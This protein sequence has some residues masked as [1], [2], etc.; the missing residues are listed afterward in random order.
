MINDQLTPEEQALVE[1]LRSTPKPQI[2]ASSRA[3]IRE[4]LLDE[5][6]TVMAQPVPT[7]RPPRLLRFAYGLVAAIVVVVAAIVIAQTRGQL[8]QTGSEVT[9]TGSQIP[10]AVVPSETSALPTATPEPTETATT[11]AATEISPTPTTVVPSAT[12]TEIPSTATATPEP[13]ETATTQAPTE[14]SPTPTTVVPSAT[15]TEIPPTATATPFTLVVV[16]G[17]ISSI[18]DNVIT[19]YDF[20]I[21]VTPEHPILNLL[22]TGD[23]IRVEGT[24]A[25]DGVVLATNV[26]NIPSETIV[27]TG[28]TATVSLDGPVEAIDGNQITVN[29]IQVVV[30]PADPILQTLQVGNFI[31]VEGNF[32]N[33]GSNIVLVVVNITVINNVIVESDPQCWFHDDAMGMGH[34]HCDGMG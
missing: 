22:N 14:V 31:T 20:S 26:G 23:I 12:M 34:W 1:Q 33:T 6:R 3:T 21:E 5:Y 16:E 24:T 18:V 19:V 13:S 30:D 17:P 27:S 9:L 10:V 11:Q 15:M 32:E 28:T 7:P 29:G 8:P 25:S 4:R 2:K